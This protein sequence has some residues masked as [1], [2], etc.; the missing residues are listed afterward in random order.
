MAGVYGA[1]A[2]VSNAILLHLHLVLHLRRTAGLLMALDI[3]ASHGVWFNAISYGSDMASQVAHDHARAFV[4]FGDGATVEEI[5]ALFKRLGR[6]GSGLYELL[7]KCPSMGKLF[8]MW[9]AATLV[10]H[11]K[12]LVTTCMTKPLLCLHGL[13][14]RAVCVRTTY[15]HTLLLC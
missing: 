13:S 10:V 15:Q 5:E 1:P 7:Q 8:G 4:P 2:S 12:P 3:Y 9:P 14:S 6:I 11:S